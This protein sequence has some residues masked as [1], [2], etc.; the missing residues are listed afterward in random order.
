MSPSENFKTYRAALKNALKQHTC[1]IP[2]FTLLVKD[3]HTTCE[4]K[5][6]KV[7]YHRSVS[8]S[9]YQVINAG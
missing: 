4:I 3:I 1:V 9:A 8:F 2:F 6:T 7:I 5:K